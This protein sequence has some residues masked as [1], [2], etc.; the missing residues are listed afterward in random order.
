[1]QVALKQALPLLL[2]GHAP[3]PDLSLLSGASLARRRPA[4]QES[5][6]TVGLA[7]KLRSRLTGLATSTAPMVSA[8]GPRSVGARPPA[9]DSAVGSEAYSKPT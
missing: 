4:K 7:R 2:H 1:M 3:F 8:F 9:A 6:M 5:S